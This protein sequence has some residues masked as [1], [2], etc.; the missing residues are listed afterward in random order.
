MNRSCVGGVDNKSRDGVWEILTSVPIF[1]ELD[2]VLSST[3]ALLYWMTSSCTAPLGCPSPR[4]PHAWPNL[5]EEENEMTRSP[6]SVENRGH[7]HIKSHLEPMLTGSFVTLALRFF[8]FVV[9]E[10]LFC[11]KVWNAELTLA[12]SI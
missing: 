9:W 4:L 12:T 10:L 8:P 6:F 11:D 5:R 2:P 3:V 7:L 1:S